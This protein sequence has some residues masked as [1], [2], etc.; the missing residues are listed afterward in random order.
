I[1]LLLELMAVPGGERFPRLAL[2]PQSKKEGA[3]RALLRQLDGLARR[4]PLLLLFED[5]HWIDP[6]SRELLDS[7]VARVE[8]L[9]VLLLATFRPDFAVPWA[10]QSHVTNLTL[11]RLS[12]GDGAA[13]V[14]QLA[15]PKTRLADA[16][17][18]EIVERTDGIPLFIEELTNH[19]IETNLLVEDA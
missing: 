6:T 1:S 15:G 18:D 17:I 10:D 8:R 2:S 16:V 14:R 7:I 11:N 4:Q 3:F 9:P 5:I 13:L 12:R 19:V